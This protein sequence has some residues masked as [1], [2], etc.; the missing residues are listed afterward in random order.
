MLK[1]KNLGMIYSA[2][3]N[4]IDD[5]KQITGVGPVLERR[6]QSAGIYRFE[7]VRNWTA[8]TIAFLDEELSLGGR[9][10][11]EDWVSQAKALTRKKAKQ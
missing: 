5:L 4:V 9:I 2:R 8:S 7:Q 1:D 3:P 10:E 11:R 6:L